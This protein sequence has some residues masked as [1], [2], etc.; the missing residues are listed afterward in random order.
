MSGKNLTSPCDVLVRNV[1]FSKYSF[2]VLIA[3]WFCIYFIHVLKISRRFYEGF[4]FLQLLIFITLPKPQSFYQKYVFWEW[5]KTLEK[6]LT[7]SNY[8]LYMRRSG[9]T[10]S[11]KHVVILLSL[12]EKCPNTNLF[13]VRIFPH[14]DWTGQKKRHIW[15][16]SRSVY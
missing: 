11:D 14:S 13:L 1:Y 15:N 16:F 3:F 5:K 10:F 7:T 8:Y 2:S 12:R 4:D 6:K 9:D